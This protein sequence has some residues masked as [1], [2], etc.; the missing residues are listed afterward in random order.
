MK[1]FRLFSQC[2]N[3]TTTTTQFYSSSATPN[4]RKQVEEERINHEDRVVNITKLTIEQLQPEISKIQQLQQQNERLQEAAVT[5]VDDRSRQKVKKKEE[6]AWR[7]TPSPELN[8]LVNHYLMLSKI[9]LTCKLHFRHFQVWKII[10]SAS[11]FSCSDHNGWLCNGTSTVRSLNVFTVFSWNWASVVRRQFHQP[12]L[13]DAV[14]RSDVADEEPSAGQRIF[15]ASPCCWLCY[16]RR[17]V[18]THDPRVRLQSFDSF[19]R[20]RQLGALHLRVHSDEE[21]QHLE[22]LGRIGCRC[23]PTFDGLGRMFRES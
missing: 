10:F 16:S 8:Q 19:A 4:A 18:R 5:T 9:R 1:L 20:C 7:V 17:F 22:H 13:R 21:I 2:F 12:V 23:D 14:R 3:Q 15:D 11:S 6:L